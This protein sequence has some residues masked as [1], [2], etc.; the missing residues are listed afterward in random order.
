MWSKSAMT[1]LMNIIDLLEGFITLIV[2]GS[3]G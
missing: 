3:E 1:L 2:I